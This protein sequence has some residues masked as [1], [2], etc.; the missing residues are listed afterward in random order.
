MASHRMRCFEVGPAF[1]Q[2]AMSKAPDHNAGELEL[3][4]I[5]WIGCAPGVSHH[6]LVTFGDDVFNGDM[7]VGE[8]LERPSNILLRPFRT[9]RCARRNVGAMV[10]KLRREIYIPDIY[11]LTI[12]E[13]R[14]MIA[15]ELLHFFMGESGKR[16]RRFC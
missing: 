5:R 14:K 3:H 7:H 9:S 13:L 10:H 16:T 11:V 15:D 1:H 2:L 8:L 12:D 4:S 6:Y